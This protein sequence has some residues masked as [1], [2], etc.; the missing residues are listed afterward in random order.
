MRAHGR[1]PAA[2][3]PGCDRVH[4]S[5][6]HH[7][8]FHG[9]P[10][11]PSELLTGPTSSSGPGPGPDAPIR[12]RTRGARWPT[13]RT[14]AASCMVIVP[15]THGRRVVHG[16]RPPM[17]GPGR[18]RPPM[19]ATPRAA[20]LGRTPFHGRHAAPC[21]A[22][23]THPPTAATPRIGDRSPHSAWRGAP[24]GGRRRRR[25]ARARAGHGGAGQDAPV[26]ATEPQCSPAHA[27]VPPGR[28]GTDSGPTAP[29]KGMLVRLRAGPR[30]GASAPEP[31]AVPYVRRLRVGSRPGDSPRGR[32]DVALLPGEADMRPAPG[33]APGAGA[34]PPAPQGWALST[35]PVPSGSRAPRRGPGPRRRAS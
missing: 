35:G 8:R 29:P 33:V 1:P 34:A 2:R 26:R 16:D 13:P 10:K 17:P 20:M 23:Q 31:G 27:R 9:Q 12:H 7:G 11:P 14:D 30:H 15:T 18:T 5:T 24:Q 28:A 25:R 32:W 21:T 3:F 6:A 22:A 19:T 4:P